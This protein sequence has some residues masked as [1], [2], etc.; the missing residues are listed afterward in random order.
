MASRP[1][2]YRGQIQCLERLEEQGRAFIIR[3]EQP[4]L[5]R[6]EQ[7]PELAASYYL[8]GYTTMKERWPELQSFL[9]A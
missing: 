9:Q 4:E 1:D 5:P 3:P 7:N 8:H 2:R 6:L